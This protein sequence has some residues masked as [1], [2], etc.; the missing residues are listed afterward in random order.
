MN[1]AVVYDSYLSHSILF[2]RILLITQNLIKVYA[3]LNYIKN[4]IVERKATRVDVLL[5]KAS[6][7]RS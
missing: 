3:N 4:K 2:L 7:Q 5:T 6:V 1:F